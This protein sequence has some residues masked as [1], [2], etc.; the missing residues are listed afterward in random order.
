MLAPGLEPTWLPT[1]LLPSGLLNVARKGE[2]G[3]RKSLERADKQQHKRRKS[4]CS[5]KANSFESLQSEMWQFGALEGSRVG[6][7]VVVVGDKRE[8]S[9]SLFWGI[10]PYW[11]KRVLSKSPTSSGENFTLIFSVF[12]TGTMPEV[13]TTE[14]DSGGAPFPWS[15]ALSRVLPVGSVTWLS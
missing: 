10:S 12:P 4:P 13:G 9:C 11:Q 1:V 14:K 7:S 8:R 6:K 2:V 5:P 15:T 3:E